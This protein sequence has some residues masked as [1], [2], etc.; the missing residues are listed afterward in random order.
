[1]TAK[2]FS[3]LIAKLKDELDLNDNINPFTDEEDI[4]R[5]INEGIEDAEAEIHNLFEDYFLTKTNL[6]MTKDDPFMSLP[7]DIYANKIRRLFYFPTEMS[8]RYEIK[9]LRDI[10]KIP[11]IS[12]ESNYRYYINN[13]LADGNRLEIYPTPRETTSDILCIY[14]RSARTCALDGTDDDLYIDIPEFS[15]FILA[16]AKAS[17]YE[18]DSDPRA[19]L[20][21]QERERLR[22]A[23]VSSLTRAIPD[24]NNEVPLDI[25]FY[26][27]FVGNS[28]DEWR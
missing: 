25:K 24:D 6:A 7:L 21:L 23:I 10:S 8:Q 3:F 14:L 4:R 11:Y 19:A 18:K 17:I 5:Y 15:R 20:A 9:R 27:D 1:M 2:T 13:S 22:T 26:R 16:Y 12:N 28:Y